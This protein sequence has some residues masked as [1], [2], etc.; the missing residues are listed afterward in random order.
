VTSKSPEDAKFFNKNMYKLSDDQVNKLLAGD[1]LFAAK[2]GR[3]RERQLKPCGR[4]SI[5]HG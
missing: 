1:N 3:P 5:V 4:L 2:P